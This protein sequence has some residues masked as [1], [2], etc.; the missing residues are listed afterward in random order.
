MLTI[1]SE[2]NE[3]NEATDEVCHVVYKIGHKP[4]QY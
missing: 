4:S 1:S 3:A 2:A